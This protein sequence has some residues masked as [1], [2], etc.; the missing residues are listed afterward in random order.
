[1]DIS[2]YK[3][4]IEKAIE[5]FAVDFRDHALCYVYEADVQAF[6]YNEIREKLEEQDLFELVKEV[7]LY[8]FSDPPTT[9]SLI[10]GR[11]SLLHCQTAIPRRE[12]GKK[13]FDIGVWDISELG[14]RI[15][16]TD[17]KV[18]I[19]IEIKYHWNT[20]IIKNEGEDS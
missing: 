5:E 16:H 4:I 9:D 10:K 11:T 12:G 17:K 19:A 2:K 20:R 8:T 15:N 1:M 18:S 3:V 6:L 7:P 14:K 13:H